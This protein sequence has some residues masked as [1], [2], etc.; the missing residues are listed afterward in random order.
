[1]QLPTQTYLPVNWADG[2]KI[3]KFHFLAEQQA[4]NWQQA[5]ASR[6]GITGYNY[7]LFYQPQLHK[8]KRQIVLTTDNQQ[9]VSVRLLSCQ[10]ITA[11]GYCIYFDEETI[12]QDHV[13]SGIVPGLQVPY[14]QLAATDAVYYVV[15]A[16]NPYNR[17]PAGQPDPEETQMRPPFT[18]PAYS[19]QLVAAPE[20]KIT[21][22]GDFHL[23]VGKI[24]ISEGKVM[25]DEDYIPPCT[26]TA[27]FGL[28]MDVHVSL[29]QF[30]SSMESY[31]LQIQQKIIQKRQQNDLAVVIMELCDKMNVYMSREY[32]QLLQ[33]QVYQ[34]PVY[35]FQSLAGLARL[36]KNSIDIYTGTIKDELLNYFTD[37][38]GITQGELETVAV[39]L[40]NH[41][42]SHIDI[43]LSVQPARNF[44]QLVLQLFSSL[45]SLE[46]IGKKREAGIFVKEQLMIPGEEVTARKRRSFLAD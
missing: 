45:A 20:L 16:V 23:P 26:C 7:G 32:Q 14:A 38:C 15:L 13:L 10:A 19:L 4:G 36:L 46:Y 29:E 5:L 12:G 44:W 40:C 42:Y 8:A 2:M 11:G 28:L 6:A 31:I 22:S 9:Q 34:P 35:M 24:K 17:V 21:G 43:G 33:V 30:Y 39:A 41:Q 25:L 37:W 27:A 18:A 3:N 1:M